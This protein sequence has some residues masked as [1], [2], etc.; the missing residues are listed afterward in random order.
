MRH[1]PDCHDRLTDALRSE[2]VRGAVLATVRRRVAGDDAQDVAQAVFCEAL[3]APSIPDNPRELPLWLVGIARHV[4]V[5]HFRKSPRELHGL[6][7]DMP[8]PMCEPPRFDIRQ[9]VEKV[10]ARLGQEAKKTLLWMVMERE[11][12]ELQTIAREEKLSPAAVRAR[13]YRLR[14]TLRRDLAYLLCGVA[15]VLG[16]AGAREALLHGHAFASAS[17]PITESPAVLP[18]WLLGEHT[19]DEVVPAPDVDDVVRRMLSAAKGATLS[20]QPN[21]ATIAGMTFHVIRVIEGEGSDG[22][23][24]RVE[25]A[26]GHGRQE[27]IRVTRLSDGRI[28]VQATGGRVR[29]GIVLGTPR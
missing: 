18:S 15:L 16:G 9:A 21:T 1:S 17:S 10:V 22:E 12:V 27:E 8:E 23:G 5:D 25:L 4:A 14:R 6:R 24:L 28:A 11:G 29:G 3:D 20:V 13:V 7:D 2:E 19:V 26:D